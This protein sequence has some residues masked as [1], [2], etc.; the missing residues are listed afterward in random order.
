MIHKLILQKIFLV[1]FFAMGE[2]WHNWHHAYPWDYA[3]SEYGWFKRWNPTKIT[4]DVW[5]F[6]G[7][8]WDRKRAVDTWNLAKKELNLNTLS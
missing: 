2:G 4:I 6:F 1:S 8:V 5:A 3:T 7:L